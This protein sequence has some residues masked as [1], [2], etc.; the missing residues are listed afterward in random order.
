MP[1]PLDATDERARRHPERRGGLRERHP[2][3][4]PDK[5]RAEFGGS[6]RVAAIACAARAAAHAPPPLP[7]RRCRPVLAHR[8]AAYRAQSRFG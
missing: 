7:A 5:E 4:S 8:L 1:A 6:P 2:A 3:G